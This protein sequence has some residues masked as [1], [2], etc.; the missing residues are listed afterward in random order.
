[1]KIKRIEGVTYYNG[2][3]GIS[4]VTLT[5]MLIKEM[6]LKGA[7]VEYSID[8]YATWSI[9]LSSGGRATT[10]RIDTSVIPFTVAAWA[11]SSGPVAPE[12]LTEDEVVSIIRYLRKAIEDHIDSDGVND[13]DEIN[14]L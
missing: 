13:F 11:P 7:H 2:D 6:G 8:E 3:R 1:M 4:I 5:E 9:I 10:V 14:V 12:R